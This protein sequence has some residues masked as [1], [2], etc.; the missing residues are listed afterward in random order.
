MRGQQKRRIRV[1][2]FDYD[3]SIMT[4]SY[5]SIGQYSTITSSYYVLSAEFY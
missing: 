2:K 1:I 5:L 4:P 3:T